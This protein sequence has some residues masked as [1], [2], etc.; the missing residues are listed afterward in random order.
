ML[1]E[2]DDFPE[3]ELMR[4]ALE[5]GARGVGG[6]LSP[7][8]NHLVRRTAAMAAPERHVVDGVRSLIQAGS[9][10][11]G[12]ELCRLRP[13]EVRR[14][15]GA[16][17][18]PSS[19]VEPMVRWVMAENPARV[20]DAGCGSGRFAAA[21]AR[22]DP[23][24]PIVAVDRDPVAT[25]L[26]RGTLAVLGATRP[27]VLQDDYTRMEL[28]PIAGRTAFVGNPPYVRHHD[29]SPAAKQWIIEAGERLGHRASGLSGLHAHF[30]VATALMARQGDLGCF[31]TSAEW[32]D[33]GYGS[34][35]R[36]LFLNGLGGRALHVI[37]P[38]AAPFDDAMT[39]AVIT[40]F[41][42]GA[43]HAGVVG[44]VIANS[45]DLND[46]S[47]GP[48]LDIGRLASSNRWSEALRR[49]SATTADGFVS[50]GSI[51]RV[52]RG[53][54]TGGNGFFVMTAQQ[55]ID[56]GIADWCRPAITDGKEILNS[57]GLV[58]AAITRKVVLT[59]PRN[60]VR[61]EHPAVDVYL[62]R[63]E[64]ARPGEVPLSQRYI[65]AHR[66]PWWYLGHQ[67]PAPIVASYMARQPPR[68]AL[69]P[70]G[71]LVVN[72]AHCIYPKEAMDKRGVESLVA[73]LNA[74]RDRFRGHGRTYQGGLE[75]FEPR[76]MEG[77]LVER[78]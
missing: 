14:S 28:L 61:S 75:K 5:L 13:P 53:L 51:A 36:H 68:F 38:K 55:A 60:F 57:V 29:L 49:R 46:L 70:D 33:V 74:S 50:L 32:L 43:I 30:F 78:S 3:A 65:C 20:V 45:G 77:L 11:L 41:E 27:M 19:I 62:A 21:V 71:L 34:V 76:E 35:V 4:L 37:E 2:M 40:C 47:Q 63:G 39:T 7:S 12:E 31:V 18:T 23:N 58:R 64:T 10:P 72:I 22:H 9:D 48:I 52:S 15:A 67:E 16:F 42:P 1:A 8:E 44:T 69:N 56:R 24:L 17:F 26:T 66:K 25:L 59:L 6:P 73:D 54:V